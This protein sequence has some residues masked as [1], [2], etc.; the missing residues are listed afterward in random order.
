MD[1]PV[2]FGQ[3]LREL[4]G[5]PVEVTVRKVRKQRS[6][7]QSRYYWG[8]VVDMLAQFCGYDREAMH[9]ALKWKFLRLEADSPLPTVRSTT[10]LSTK[11][12]EDYLD[13]VRTWAGADLGVNIPL[14]NECEVS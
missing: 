13:C 3:A 2:V 12:F 8:V 5:K 1:L 11:E 9:E 7:R 4:A 6:D 10:D 14:P